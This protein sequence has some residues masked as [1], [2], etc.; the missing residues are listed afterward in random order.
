MNGALGT[1][2]PCLTAECEGDKYVAP[3]HPDR[4]PGVLAKTM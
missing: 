3:K 2:A 4:G 1:R